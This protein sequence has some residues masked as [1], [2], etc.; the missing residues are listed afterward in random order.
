[1]VACL[2]G[3]TASAITYRSN[4][5]LEHTF[6]SFER[7]QDYPRL[8]RDLRAGDT[9]LNPSTFRD[10]SVAL[11]LLHTGHPVRA[12]AYIARAAREQPSNVQ[13]WIAL[14]RL[15][16]SR[17]RRAAARAS[18]RHARKLNPHLP[19]QIPPAF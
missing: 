4:I 6:T 15:Q 7:K 10:A 12:E 1:V 3:A 11:G 9:P 5:Q 19:R 2:A 14:V 17:G 13:P 16:L 18:Y 8:L